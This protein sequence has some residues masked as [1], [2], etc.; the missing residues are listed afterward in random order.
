M[1]LIVTIIM[2]GDID[3]DNH[4]NNNNNV[5][6]NIYPVAILAQAGGPPWAGQPC[7]LFYDY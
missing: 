3:I 4:D 1:C 6:K 7:L 2:T 5:D